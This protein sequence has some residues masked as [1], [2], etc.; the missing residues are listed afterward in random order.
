[1]IRAPEVPR[2]FVDFDGVLRP[3]SASR[4]MLDAAC[5]GRFAECVL[6]H[7]GARVVI[8]STW[9]LAYSL[10]ELRAMFP[11][12]LAARIE[13]ATPM[14]RAA[15]YHRIR[16][17]E[18]AAYLRKLGAASSHWIAVDDKP[19]LYGPNAPVLAID[20]AC[21]FDDAAARALRCWLDGA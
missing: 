15:N 21:G 14:L 16:D 4:D 3:D 1:M 17:D 20:P 6:T 8:A 5:V 18:V 9:R 13:G 19:A 2:I 11:L 12:E 10:D 7:S